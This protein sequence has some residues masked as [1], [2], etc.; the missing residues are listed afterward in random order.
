[1]RVSTAAAARC[2]VV[3]EFFEEPPRGPPLQPLRARMADKVL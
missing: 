3:A 2:D 1:V